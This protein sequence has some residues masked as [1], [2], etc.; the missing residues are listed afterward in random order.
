MGIM[1]HHEADK[2]IIYGVKTHHVL[3][4]FN[5]VRPSKRFCFV[6]GY[7]EPTETGFLLVFRL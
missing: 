2:N 3:Q 7:G 5:R 1:G 6:F 4:F